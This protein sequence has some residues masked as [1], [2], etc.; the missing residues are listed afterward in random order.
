MT[1]LLDKLCHCHVKTKIQISHP[2]PVLQS[3]APLDVQQVL[4]GHCGD[5]TVI[6]ICLTFA[7]LCPAML[8]SDISFPY[9]VWIGS[10]VPKAKYGEY[11]SGEKHAASVIYQLESEFSNLKILKWCHWSIIALPHFLISL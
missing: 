10:R 5:W 9:L 3:T 4:P 7:R 8:V 6:Q 2:T 1:S 11:G